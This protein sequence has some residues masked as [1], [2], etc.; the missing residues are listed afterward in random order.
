NSFRFSPRSLFGPVSLPNHTT[1]TRTLAPTKRANRNS[2]RLRVPLSGARRQRLGVLGPVVQ[3]RRIEIRAVRPDQRMH[4][5]INLDFI[6]ERQVSQWAIKR[7]TQD[8]LEIYPLLAAVVELHQQ[9][10]WRND[11]HTRDAVNKM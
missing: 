4:L 2:S 9:S 6:K 5:G 11:T 3:S 10:I 8:R 7:A 1:F